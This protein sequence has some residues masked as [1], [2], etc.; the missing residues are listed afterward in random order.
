MS[1]KLS[2]AR[3]GYIVELKAYV[4]GYKLK[5]QEFV[6]T[7]IYM[8]TLSITTKAIQDRFI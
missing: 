4:E 5:E 7:V 1:T 3:D 6:S 2:N 8:S